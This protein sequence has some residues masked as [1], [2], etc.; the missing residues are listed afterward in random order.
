MEP[1]QFAVLGLDVLPNGKEDVNK[2]HWELC[3]E[4]L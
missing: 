4:A 2:C 1:I 3:L